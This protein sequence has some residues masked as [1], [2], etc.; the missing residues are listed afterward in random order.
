MRKTAFT[1][2]ELLVVISI[3]GI[4]SAV[5]IPS[6]NGY[7][8]GARISKAKNMLNVINI[9]ESDA[10]ASDR[11]YVEDKVIESG[12]HKGEDNKL[13]IMIKELNDSKSEDKYEYSLVVDSDKQ[14]TYIAKATNIDDNNKY[15]TINE[16]GKITVVE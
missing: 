9:L 8:D 12:E 15:I 2:I 4:L 5:G 3:I 1:L 13:L 16:T 14:Q 11:K 7:I 6:Y 10:Y